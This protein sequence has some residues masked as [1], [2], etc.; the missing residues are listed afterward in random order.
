V[1]KLGE[2]LRNLKEKKE[3]K[4]MIKDSPFK[5]HSQS[6]E[7][8]IVI[9]LILVL[10]F[11]SSILG[12]FIL[13]KIL[14]N[15]KREFTKERIA[16]ERVSPS[17]PQYI[18]QNQSMPIPQLE[19][20]NDSFQDIGSLRTQVD[21]RKD[22]KKST[23]QKKVL[24]SQGPQYKRIIPMYQQD[25]E[26]ILVQERSPEERT[27]ILREKKLMDNLLINAEEARLRGKIE[28]AIALYTEYLKSKED[29]DVL[30]NLAG[31]YLLKG[32][33]KRAEKLLERALSIKYDEIFELNLLIA[34]W[35]QG[36]KDRVCHSLREKN[37]SP[38]SR[39]QLEVLKT[40]CK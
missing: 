16:L 2:I 12:G 40:Y 17:S 20:K 13:P 35:K 21:D 11:I 1:S 8:R 23:Q 5:S 18:A 32:E 7:K 33:Y 22:T 39:D 3:N 24:A 30:N 36:Y 25:E 38:N 26:R 6:K 14:T 4:E 10:L 27:P 28:E 37:F 29:P 9:T 34:W 31:L 19:M 15:L